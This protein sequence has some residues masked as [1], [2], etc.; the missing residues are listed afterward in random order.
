MTGNAGSSVANLWRKNNV[1]SEE[2]ETQ[3]D[4]LSYTLQKREAAS[5]TTSTREYKITQD[6]ARESASDK[7]AVKE[8][9]RERE[10]T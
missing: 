3:P 2:K 5:S 8:K 7:K 9:E 4:P 6:C 10:T 1:M